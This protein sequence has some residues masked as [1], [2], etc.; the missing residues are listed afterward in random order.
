MVYSQQICSY[1]AWQL[2]NSFWSGHLCEYV[3]VCVC[4]FVCVCVCVV[5]M[6][7]YRT[8]QPIYIL[9]TLLWSTH[10][11]LFCVKTTMWTVN[12]TSIVEHYVDVGLNVIR[13]IQSSWFSCY[14]VSLQG[15]SYPETLTYIIS[16]TSCY[17]GLEHWRWVPYEGVLINT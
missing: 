16:N 13:K 10:F 7:I 1:R 9:C 5:K 12:I 17:K 3:C 15:T 11:L 6:K 4:V 8:V 14:I 2:T